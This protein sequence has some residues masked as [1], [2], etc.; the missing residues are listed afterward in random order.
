LLFL[1]VCGCALAAL[2]AV[3]ST[4]VDAKKEGRDDGTTGWLSNEVLGDVEVVLRNRNH[5]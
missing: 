4:D 5:S 1:P 3:I 2:V